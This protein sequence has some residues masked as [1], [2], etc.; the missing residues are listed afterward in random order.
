ML[1]SVMLVMP[2]RATDE[3][4]TERVMPLHDANR[5]QNKKPEDA[6]CDTLLVTVRLGFGVRHENLYVTCT[7]GSPFLI[8]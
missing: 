7:V 8:S 6:L 2:F 4:K 3:Q 5:E 1:Q